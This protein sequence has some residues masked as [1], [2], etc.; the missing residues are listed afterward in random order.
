MRETEGRSQQP[1]GVRKECF[2]NGG[3][4]LPFGL[5]TEPEKLFFWPGKRSDEERE[6]EVRAGRA[7]MESIMNRARSQRTWVKCFTDFIMSLC[8]LIC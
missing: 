1:N 2:Y 6:L 8:R 4:I 5:E 7:G 3:E